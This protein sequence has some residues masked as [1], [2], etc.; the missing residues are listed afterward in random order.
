M[1]EYFVLALNQLLSYTWAFAIVGFIIALW[2]ERKA[3]ID[4]FSKRN[5]EPS[6]RTFYPFAK[7]LLFILG[8]FVLTLLAFTI[9]NGLISLFHTLL[10]PA[11]IPQILNVGISENSTFF[12]AILTD[13]SY[14]GSYAVLLTIMSGLLF[15]LSAGRKWLKNTAGVLLT[16]MVLLV[17]TATLATMVVTGN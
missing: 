15:M 4:S 17:F 11:A 10:Y 1:H 14:I 12:S 13:K 8:G 16:T 2:S 7:R 3:F 6:R 9:T 5:E